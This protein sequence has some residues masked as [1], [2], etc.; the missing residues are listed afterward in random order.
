MEEVS[1]SNQKHAAAAAMTL[2]I[3]RDEDDLL[4]ININNDSLLPSPPHLG[5]KKCCT[6][7]DNIKSSICLESSPL[8]I[9]Q[10]HLRL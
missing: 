3:I 5:T 9:Q 1:D 2:E 4:G 10:V 6:N 8:F 7:I